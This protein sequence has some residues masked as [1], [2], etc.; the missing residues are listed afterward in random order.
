MTKILHLSAKKGKREKGYILT[1]LKARVI[2]LSPNKKI[3]KNIG[4]N[5]NNLL[6]KNRTCG[7]MYIYIIGYY[8]KNKILPIKLEERC[9]D[10]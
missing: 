3:I 2:F 5:F 8:A 7:I 4:K 6:E 9:L 10:K 1:R